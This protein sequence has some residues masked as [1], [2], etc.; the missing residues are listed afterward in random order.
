MLV[1]ISNFLILLLYL[2][3]SELSSHLIQILFYLVVVSLI[4]YFLVNKILVTFVFGKIKLIYK[5]IDSA[6]SENRIS[7]NFKDI[8][9]TEVNDDVIEWAEKTKREI[10]ELKLLEN[11]RK[12]F[13]GNVSHELKTPIFSIQGYLHTLLDGALYDEKINKKYLERAASNV[14]RL[15]TIVEDLEEINSIDEQIGNKTFSKFDLNRLINDLIVD[16]NVHAQQKKISLEFEDKSAQSNMVLGDVESIRRVLTNLLINSIKYG[17]ENG[18]TTVEIFD[19]EDKVLVEISDNGI[20]IPEEDIK[21]VFDRFY[22]VD[23]S[24]S[25]ELGGSGLGLSIV[26][27]IVEAHGGTVTVKSKEKKG[28]TFGFTLLKSKR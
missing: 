14:M 11:Y 28:S 9:I 2:E 1:L 12:N 17:I 23:P 22:R 4:S 25:R 13:V 26:K 8:S 24:R 15:Q 21:H 5:F 18:K 10:S 6:K 20:G 27:H 16:L 3:S 7:K 19:I